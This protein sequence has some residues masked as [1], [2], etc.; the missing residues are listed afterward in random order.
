MWVN[1]SQIISW[2]ELLRA[3]SPFGIAVAGIVDTRRVSYPKQ[4]EIGAV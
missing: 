4:F 1:K 2:W 3:Y